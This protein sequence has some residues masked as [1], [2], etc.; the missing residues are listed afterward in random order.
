MGTQTQPQW[1]ILTDETERIIEFG[2]EKKWFF[3]I[4]EE[5]GVIEKPIL[6]PGW[7][8]EPY[9]PDCTIIHQEALIRLDAVKARFPSKQVIVGHEIVVAPEVEAPAKIEPKR[10][11]QPINVPW[12]DIATVIVTLT[13]GVAYVLVSGMLMAFSAAD[14]CLI[15]VL[16]DSTESWIS[17][18]EWLD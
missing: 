15:V 6:K 17:I 4:M 9:D 12:K 2:I 10:E 13:A 5:K 14:P 8:F 11:I 16:D 3:R 18:C 7:L 1:K